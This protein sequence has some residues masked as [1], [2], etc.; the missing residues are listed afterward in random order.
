MSWLFLQGQEEASWEGPSLDG[1]PSA[2]LKLMP[3]AEASYSPDNATDACRDFQSG[4]TRE[5]STGD[6]GAASSMSSAAASPVRTSASLAMGQE[7]TASAADSG[8]TRLE[9]FARWNPVSRLWRTHQ[10]SLFGGWA[11]FSETWPRWGSMRDGE[12][13]R[14]ATLEHDTSVKGS[15][16]SLPTT[17]KNESKGSSRKRYLG[18]RHFRGAKM[19]E[20]LRTSEADP[21]Y[22]A[23][24]FSELVMGWPTGWS[25]LEP[26]ATA[27]FQEWSRSHGECL[28]VAE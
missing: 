11:E 28:G 2:L 23:P 25:A 19:S 3:T 26:L 22:L 24:D 9:S 10:R 12:C 5:P 20:G 7:S 8:P 14:L 1:A 4:T 13:S 27:R 21:I 17:G 16:L 15:G 6:P 18:S